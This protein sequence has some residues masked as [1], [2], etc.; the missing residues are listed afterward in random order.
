MITNHASLIKHREK[1][2]TKPCVFYIWTKEVKEVF[3]PALMIWFRN[4]RKLNSYLVSAKLH[5]L[6]SINGSF[7]FKGKQCQTCHNVKKIETF[8][9]TGTGENLKINHQLNCNDQCLVYLCLKQYVGQTVEESRYER[10]NYKNTG[11]N[12]QEFCT[13][14]QQHFMYEHFSEEE[15]HSFWEVSLLY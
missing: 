8:T 1:S 2:S 15:H 4:A 6:E 11:C 3:T 13:C 7:Q 14:T 12:Y 10:N 9:S 5:R